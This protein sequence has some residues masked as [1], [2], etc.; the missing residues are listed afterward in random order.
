MSFIT[1]DETAPGLYDWTADFDGESEYVTLGSDIELWFNED[2]LKGAG[3]ISIINTDTS[4]TLETINVSS[5]RVSIDG[6][7]VV[8]NPNKW[9]DADSSYIVVAAPGA[10][11][12]ASGNH[13][14][15]IDGQDV[16]FVTVEESAVIVEDV[17]F[18]DGI[19]GAAIDTDIQITFNT[20]VMAG[21]GVIEI[22]RASNNKLVQS[23][24]AGAA[25]SVSIDGDVVTIDRGDN[26]SYGTDYYVYIAPGAFVDANGTAYAGNLNDTIK[27]ST[28]SKPATVGTIKVSASTRGFRDFSIKLGSDLADETVSVYRYDRFAGEMVLIRTLQTDENGNFNFTYNVPRL[29]VNDNVYVVFGRHAV[30]TQLV[31]KA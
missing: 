5:W 23:F 24:T 27:F 6:D 10:F 8:I 12:D 31:T 2:V 26:Y 15:A 20:E 1:A 29:V 4:E 11:V 17:D 28:E 18:S 22:R 7:V 30:A 16:F 9:L 13:S 21:N 14:E 19:D 25:S 3:S